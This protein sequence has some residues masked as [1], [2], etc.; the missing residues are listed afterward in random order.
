MEKCAACFRLLNGAAPNQQSLNCNFRFI[1][2]N[3]LLATYNTELKRIAD[4]YNGIS[5]NANMKITD[6]GQN[7]QNPNNL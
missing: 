5:E 1:K 2:K 7:K 3:G 4:K 6:N